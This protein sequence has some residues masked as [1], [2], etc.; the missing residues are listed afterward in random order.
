MIRDAIINPISRGKIRL[1]IPP[2]RLPIITEDRATG[3]DKTSLKVPFSRSPE[4]TL[5]AK[6]RVNRLMII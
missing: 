4:I 2:I 1:K 5:Y 6:S 3:L